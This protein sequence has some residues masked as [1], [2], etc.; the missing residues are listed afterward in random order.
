[1][2]QLNRFR[3]SFNLLF[4][5]VLF[6]RR[7]VRTSLCQPLVQY[8]FKDPS[9]PAYSLHYHNVYLPSILVTISQ[10]SCISM[11]VMQKSF[12]LFIIWSHLS[13]KKYQNLLNHSPL[14][15]SNFNFHSERDSRHQWGRE[16]GIK[17]GGGSPFQLKCR[18]SGVMPLVKEGRDVRGGLGSWGLGG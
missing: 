13:K 15:L 11:Q 1:M 17:T 10:Y 7:L 9:F 2:K 4:T 3:S 5:P 6:L 18:I 8:S 16:L 12:K 14:C